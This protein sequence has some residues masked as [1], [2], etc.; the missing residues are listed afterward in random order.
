MGKLSK[1]RRDIFYRKAKEEG[2]RARSAYK[3]LHIDDI[4]HILG[5]PQD[6]APRRVVD[7]CAA[8]GGWSHDKL[9]KNWIDVGG[10]DT[11]TQPLIAAVDLQEMAPLKGVVQVQGDITTPEMMAAIRCCLK[12]EQADVVICDGLPTLPVCMTWMSLFRLKRLSK[13]LS[14]PPR[15]AA[16]LEAVAERRK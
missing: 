1:D 7:L 15:S 14:P 8:P 2:Y 10:G 12:G 9:F 13:H 3:L 16:Y 11:L 6:K 4:F 5:G